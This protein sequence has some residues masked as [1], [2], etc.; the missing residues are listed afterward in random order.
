[1]DGLAIAM[2][3]EFDIVSSAIQ[4]GLSVI[5]AS[6]GT[7]KTYAISH[8]VP[9]LL[10]D[11]T[12][13]E[14]GHILLVTYTNDA[15]RELSDR[16][17]KVL[18]Q[19]HA[20]AAA[21]EE[22]SALGI[23]R[24]R[25]NFDERTRSRIIGRA[26]L[27][28]DRLGVSTIHSFCQQT[29]QREGAL[30]GLP[31][32]PELI[33]SADEIIDEVL[34]D[35]WDA[36]IS[37]DALLSAIA[38][39]QNWQLADDLR[40]VRLALPIENAVPE[41]PARPF[42]EA[43]AELEDAPGAF[44]EAAIRELEDFFQQR[45][46]LT[47]KA[48]A[49]SGL[50]SLLLCLKQARSP[51]DTGFLMAVKNLST[52]GEWID[53]RTK[54]GKALKADAMN[55]QAV[56]AAR[57]VAAL[58]AR[59]SWYWRNACAGQV[60]AA[61][62]SR[63]RANRQ[64]TYDGLI[65]SLRDALRSPSRQALAARLRS[66]Y[67]VALIDESQDTDPRQFEI[68]RSVFMGFPGENPL[69]THR[70]VLI[71]DPKQA[72][73]A[74]RGADV[75]TYLAARDEAGGQ[76]FQL[77]QTFRAPAPLVRAINALFSRDK[78]L[79]KEG[80]TFSPATSGLQ[81]DVRLQ[82]AAGEFSAP[83]EAWI[84]PDAEGPA[85]SAKDNRNALVAEMAAAEIARLLAEGAMIVRTD[86]GGAVSSGQPVRPG[87]FA[88]LVSDRYEADAVT[89][90]LRAR[91]V[92]AIQAKGNDVMTSEEAGE[93]LTLLRAIN[94]PRRSGLRFAALATRLMGRDDSALRRMREDADRDDEMLAKF[95]RWQSAFEHR[96]L[97]LV[98]AEIDR[99]ESIALRLA[100]TDQGERRVTNLRHLTDLLQTA[101]MNLGNRPEHLL[102]WFSQEIARADKR[103][104]IEERQQQLE[105]D[106]EA[107]QIVT[108]HAAKGLEYNLVFCPF[109][110]SLKESRG[111]VKISTSDGSV[112]L[113]DVGLAEDPAIKSELARAALEDRLR[114]AYVALTRAKV[115]AWIVG[116]ELCGSRAPASALDWLL[117]P[118]T[119]LDF[120]AWRSAAA[121]PGRGSRHAESLDALIAAAGTPA[122]ISQRP[123]PV[124]AKNEI[125]DARPQTSVVALSP[126][127][128]PKI[129]EAWGVTSFSALT[130][131]K[132][133]RGE[134]GLPPELAAEGVAGDADLAKQ[135]TF[136]GAPAGAL[137]GTAVH[138]WIESWNFSEPDPAAVRRHLEK[139]RIP[140][141][142][143]AAALH[144]L[145]APMLRELRQAVLQGL[146]CTV[147]EAS[148][149]PAGA[150]WHFH[151]PI[152]E[153]LSSQRLAA[154]FAG[155]SGDARYAAMLAALPSGELA[156]YLQGFLDRVVFHNGA[157]GVIDW[158]TNRLGDTAGAY[159]EAS[160]LACARHSHYL[161]Q[162]HL[163]LVALR[164]YLGP[165]IPIA[166]AWLVFLRGIRSGSSNGILHIQPPA[167]LMDAMDELF[168]HPAM[169][170]CLR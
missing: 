17:R 147:A 54:N 26:L 146:D 106:A 53:G 38:T 98:L 71:G 150:E 157:W 23:F 42:A 97:A 155:H 128:R 99:E 156:G 7:G 142:A 35:L 107:V 74:F 139:Y 34:F 161:L 101:A 89:A 32:V 20:P 129:P 115:R 102:R 76:V 46:P 167:A 91:R 14:I 25:Q 2:P 80:L 64:I 82:A 141:I 88:V 94:E 163:Y 135:N 45:P 164:R 63:L 105:S 72:I 166:G 131:E 110:W 85:Y 95:V 92:P 24:L 41:P 52:I 62:E 61:V 6:A 132:H 73:Y 55:L 104:D 49:E 70:L 11:G 160:L 83:L 43:L 124:P 133:A 96:G 144:E 138:E 165:D 30:C 90:A 170:P 79:L 116:G 40:F 81:E 122:V 154:A 69:A 50:P 36:R 67:R 145:V 33:P 126:L 13:E 15:A 136:F 159:G 130:R 100:R 68:F 162:T 22:K 109:L 28:I 16:V 86:P 151:L 29:L 143:P 66:R 117:R 59:M 84:V 113:V 58:L 123:P 108:M 9:R 21:D 31:V 103:N 118:D 134:A 51:S 27:D 19:L 56:I 18:E 44:T 120:D 57:A 112:K 148:S 125:C 149:N 10:L 127:A 87:D 169:A 5:E 48:P 47:S 119:A 137:V 4:P 65:L 153:S 75:N 77:N 3:A 93:L 37:S 114:L 121:E 168:F 152:N 78:A 158:K 12:V 60:R 8:L 140:K 39:A 111:L 1:M